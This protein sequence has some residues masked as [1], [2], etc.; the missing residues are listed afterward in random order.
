MNNA[1]NLVSD[2]VSGNYFNDSRID[3]LL[4]EAKANLMA[5]DNLRREDFI[6]KLSLQML[7]KK[8]VTK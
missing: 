1:F 3:Q 7:N 6:N 5:I 4:D 2:M 8:G